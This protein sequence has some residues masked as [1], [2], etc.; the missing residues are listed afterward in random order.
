[1]AVNVNETETKYDAPADAAL[2]NLDGL[3]QVAATATPGEV[4]LDAEYYDTDDLRLLRAGITLRRR[5]GGD[6]AGWHLK[7]PVGGDTRREI[8]LPLGRA[9]RR[10]P[11]ELAELVRVHARGAPL[12]PVARLTTKRRRL[13]LLDEAGESLAEVAADDVSAE[14]LGDTAAVSRWHEVEVELT[15]G[16]RRLLKA[17][18]EL[19]RRDGLRPAGRSAKLERALGGRLP[20]PASQPSPQRSTPAGL[21]VLAYLRA[22]AAKLKS[23]DPMARRDEPDAVH[24]MRVATRRLRSTLR[25]FGYVFHRE[26]TQRLAAE[27]KWLGSVLGDARDGEVLAAH[28]QEGLSRTA[29]EQVIGPIQ[30]RVQGHFASVRATART[31]LLA[32]LDSARYFTLLDDLDRL[33]DDPPFTAQAAMPP[34]E[35]LPKAARRAFRQA[36]RRMRRA[37]HTPAGRHR[38]AALHQARKSARRARYASEAMAPATG[39]KARRF[40]RQMKKVQSVLGEHQDAVIARRVERELGISAHLA[41]ENAFSYGLLYERDVCAGERLQAQAQRVWKQ[42]SRPRYRRWMR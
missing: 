27:L 26:D 15:G 35:V 30:A 31:E 13:I 7:L 25:S 1:M 4:E 11:G 8:R 2:P 10:V 29:T 14:T 22:H 36:R 40:A 24:Q 5:R 3:P 20:E 41:G 9:G 16:D 39:A 18:D 37:T 28:L 17:A 6:D 34:A 38:N 19:L 21:V 32:A 33:L 23:L 12:R 42:A